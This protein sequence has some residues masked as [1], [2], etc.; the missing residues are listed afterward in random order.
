MKIGCLPISH[1]GAADRGWLALVEPGS[2]I[3]SKVQGNFT[4]IAGPVNERQF[5]PIQVPKETNRSVRS[6]GHQSDGLRGSTNDRFRRNPTFHGA[7]ATGSFVPKSVSH[8]PAI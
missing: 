5:G 4:P 1:F 6:P 7:A 2:Q 8:T 3:G